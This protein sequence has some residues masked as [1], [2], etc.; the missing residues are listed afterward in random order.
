MKLR[1]V[2]ALSEVVG[3]THNRFWSTTV[4]ADAPIDYE[5]SIAVLE[6]GQGEHTILRVFLGKRG[7][8]VAPT[9]VN[10]AARLRVIRIT[11]PAQG[12]TRYFVVQKMTP[13]PGP[14]WTYL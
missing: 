5:Q 8:W 3:R 12:P 13:V 2:S 11:R 10:T 1:T 9:V 6:L 4:D 14:R 7:G